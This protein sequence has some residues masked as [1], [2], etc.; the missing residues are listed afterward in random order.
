[1]SVSFTSGWSRNFICS[2]WF[3]PLQPNAGILH[4]GSVLAGDLRPLTSGPG[5]PQ[6]CDDGIQSPHDGQHFLS[7][8][9]HALFDSITIRIGLHRLAGW[10]HAP[11]HSGTAAGGRQAVRG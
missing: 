1:M 2:L 11:G 5:V 8:E 9:L 4:P 7:A 3:S 6:V 10:L